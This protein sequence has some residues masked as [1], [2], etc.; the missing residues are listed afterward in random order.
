MTT[1]NNL[2]DKENVNLLDMPKENDWI[3]SGLAFDTAFV[4]DYVSY[5]LSNSLDQY[6]ARAEYCELVLN[7]EYKGIYMLLEK[8]KADDSRINIKKL[9]IIDNE[10]PNLSGGYISKSDK[11]EGEEILGWTMDGYG[12]GPAK[13][14]HEQPKPTEITNQQD[15]YIQEVFS[16]LASTSSLNNTSL[17]EG[18][19][20]LIDIPSFVDFIIMAELTSNPDSY[21]FS[22]FFHKDRRGKLRAGP[23]WDYNLTFGNDLLLWG[24]D[25][26]KT[27]IWQIFN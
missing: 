6:A 16:D 27:D 11:I 13:F 8:L 4:R 24:F 26:S 1:Y 21:M 19:P 15:L 25:R 5:K 12:W 20:S 18:Y 7:G 14:A 9:D 2:G 17:T 3:L 10:L 23:V 22:T